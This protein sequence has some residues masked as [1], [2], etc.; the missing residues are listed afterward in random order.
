M[1][2]R[3]VIASA[4]HIRAVQ[5]R[6]QEDVQAGFGA[7]TQVARVAWEGGAGEAQAAGVGGSTQRGQRTG[8]S[9]GE[10]RLRMKL[11][12]IV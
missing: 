2:L 7:Q 4:L 8:G 12:P 1:E 3:V 10:G 5:T 6:A 11:E 9:A